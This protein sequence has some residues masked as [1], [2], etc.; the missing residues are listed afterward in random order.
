MSKMCCR[1]NFILVV[2]SQ[3][4]IIMMIM[5]IWGQYMVKGKAARESLKLS[6]NLQNECCT[7]WYCLNL[8]Y[9]KINNL[10][11]TK[12]RYSQAFPIFLYKRNS[13]G[14]CVAALLAGSC[15]SAHTNTYHNKKNYTNIII[16]CICY[17]KPE[18][19]RENLKWHCKQ[20]KSNRLK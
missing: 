11:W 4:L 7:I 18:I 1:R 12:Q 16:T 17:F 2:M 14:S 9:E 13:N 8:A 10:K 19:S 20:N 15:F 5:S 3:L 6:I